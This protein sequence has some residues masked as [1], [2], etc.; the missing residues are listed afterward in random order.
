MWALQSM[1]RGTLLSRLSLIIQG[2][3]H[4]MV[5][6]EDLPWLDLLVRCSNH[7]LLVLFDQFGTREINSQIGILLL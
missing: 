7:G 6:P 5:L 3:R 4:L 2:V 1:E